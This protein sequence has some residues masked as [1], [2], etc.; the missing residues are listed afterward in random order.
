MSGALPADWAPT[1]SLATLRLRARM[2]ETVRRHFAGTGALE[3]ETPTM[4]Q[5]ISLRQS[6]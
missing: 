4:V 2:L 5:L 1:A 6:M 3:V